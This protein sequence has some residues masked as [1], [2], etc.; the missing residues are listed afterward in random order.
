MSNSFSIAVVSL[1]AAIVG[2]GASYLALQVRLRRDQL[3][4]DER[5][6]YLEAES[7]AR[8]ASQSPEIDSSEA[9]VL[10]EMINRQTAALERLGK[11]DVVI[12]NRLPS[13]SQGGDPVD[14]VP[15]SRSDE[16]FARE[17]AHSLN[18]PLS[19]IEASALL[20]RTDRNDDIRR[21]GLKRIRVNGK[22]LKQA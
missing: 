10:A 6:M 21:V 19:Q 7:L 13:L 22:N 14:R 5:R 8:Q 3:R 12:N 15:P 4:L 2:L 17:V 11:I 1:V 9:S 20:L 18:T 16:S